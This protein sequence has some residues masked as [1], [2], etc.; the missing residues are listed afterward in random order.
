MSHG[1]ELLSVDVVDGVAYGA[2]HCK[3]RF[4]FEGVAERPNRECVFSG[5]ECEGTRPTHIPTA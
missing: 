3:L 5:D 4:E 2:R 1:E